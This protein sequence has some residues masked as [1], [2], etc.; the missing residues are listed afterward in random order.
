MKRM[1]VVGLCLV[2]AF[3]FSALAVSSAQAGT[4]GLCKKDK[5]GKYEN[6]ECTK[7]ASEAKKGKYEWEA[8]PANQ[9]FTSEG[10]VSHLIGAAGEIECKHGTDEGEF[11]KGGKLDTDT[12]KFVECE[13][14]PF[15]FTCQNTATKGEIVTH[16]LESTFIDQ[17]EKGLSGKEPKAGEVWEQFTN[18]TTLAEFEC[19]GIPFA[20]TGSV[21]GAVSNVNKALKE[22]KAG[23]KG[24]P[25]KPS[26]TETFS[27]EGAGEQDLVTTFF[28]PETGKVES[29]ASVQ[30]GVNEVD[31]TKANGYSK[32]DEIRAEDA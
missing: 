20:V 32:E 30:E 11:L 1:K 31:L 21:S 12:F 28:N 25:G 27:K 22:G 26:F 7:T 17:G 15:K 6:K 2:A 16:V 8:L 9:K 13:L 24:K 18:K 29:G 10:G 23:K 4:L 3:A 19:E 14:L 5:G